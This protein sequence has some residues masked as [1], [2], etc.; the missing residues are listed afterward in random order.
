MNVGQSPVG[1][2]R[3]RKGV[4]TI[5]GLIPR[6]SATVN[7]VM[8]WSYEELPAIVPKRN[9]DKTRVPWK[10]NRKNLA[11]RKMSQNVLLSIVN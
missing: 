3:V 4:N 9:R 2:I 10:M 5:T 11:E 1:N 6:N 8:S 7:P